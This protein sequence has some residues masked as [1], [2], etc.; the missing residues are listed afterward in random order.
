MC[1]R[2][3]LGCGLLRLFARHDD[4]PTRSHHLSLAIWEG[5]AVNG[6]LLHRNFTFRSSLQPALHEKS[7]MGRALRSLNFRSAIT[8]FHIVIAVIA[9]KAVIRSR[10]YEM[11]AEVSRIAIR[12]CSY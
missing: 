2:W 11:E 9:P 12:Y 10:S 3:T 8:A 5:T 6:E 7:S 1:L 4:A